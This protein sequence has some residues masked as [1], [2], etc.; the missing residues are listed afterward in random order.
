MTAMIFKSSIPPPAPTHTKRRTQ[1]LLKQFNGTS[2]IKYWPNWLTYDERLGKLNLPSLALRGDLIETYK[3]VHNLYDPIT[4]NSLFQFDN[5]NET[6][7]HQYKLIKPCFNT[8]VFQNFN[9]RVITIFQK[10]WYLLKLNIFKNRLDKYIHHYKFCTNVVRAKVN[11]KR[12][13]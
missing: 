12:A 6:R 8:T 2:Q 1:N 13:Q 5:N 9:N 11:C 4:T 3:I 10:R 7:Y